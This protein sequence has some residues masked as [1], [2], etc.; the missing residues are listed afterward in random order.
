MQ[1]CGISR[2]KSM[3]PSIYL[4]LAASSLCVFL[5]AAPPASASTRP[6]YGG[7]LRT[8][9]RDTATSLDPADAAPSSPARDNLLT[10]IFDRLTRVDDAGSPQPQL[11]TSW[12]S[13]PQQ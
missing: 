9:L 12:Q 10:L 5:T 8:E 4:Y 1:S 6:H 11:A 3:K 13:D 7:T 2:A